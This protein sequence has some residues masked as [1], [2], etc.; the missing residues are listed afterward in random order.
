MKL[1]FLPPNL[2]EILTEIKNESNIL[3]DKLSNNALEK[4]FVIR[5]KIPNMTT[6]WS[7]KIFAK[8]TNA[9]QF[10]SHFA[11]LQIKLECGLL[12]VKF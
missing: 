9:K 12:Q 1:L 10:E 4:R 6:S 8:F 11:R 5:D 2:N 7:H 3:Y